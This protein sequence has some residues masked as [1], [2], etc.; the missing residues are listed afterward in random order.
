MTEKPQPRRLEYIRL[1][2][3][4]HA[5]RNPKRHDDDGIRRSVDHHGFVEVP[6]IDAR[7]GRLVAGHGRHAQLVAMHTA[8]QSPPDGVTIDPDDGMWLMPVVTGWSSRSDVDA[9]AYLL[10]SNQ[11]TVAGGWDDQE[12]LA[13]LDDVQAAGL[14]DLTGFDPDQ[15]AALAGPPS[16]DRL[17][18]PGNADTSPGPAAGFGVIVECDSEQQQIT[19]MERL[20]EEGFSCRALL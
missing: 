4:E 6:A 5:N 3:V 19:L 16:A 18:D 11:L 13:V 9:E 14:L 2:R 15:L 8:G 7:T 12:L 20:L 17:P 1:D 10:A